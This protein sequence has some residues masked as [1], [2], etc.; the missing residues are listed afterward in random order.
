MTGIMF[1]LLVI[2]LAIVL[3]IGYL[4]DCASYLQRI[5]LALELLQ[6]QDSWR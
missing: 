4:R 1:E 6:K 3:L 5:A 2:A